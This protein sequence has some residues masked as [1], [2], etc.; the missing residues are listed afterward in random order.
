MTA[1]LKTCFD[2]KSKFRPSTANSKRCRPCSDARIEIRELATSKVN[3]A[4]KRGAITRQPCEVCGATKVDAHHDDYNE[5]LAVRWLC[6]PHHQQFHAQ[7]YG[8]AR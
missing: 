8:V 6:R 1:T 5:P 3:Q 4:I 7:Q 2:C